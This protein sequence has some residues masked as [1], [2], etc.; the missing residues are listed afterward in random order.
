MKFI[1]SWH[2]VERYAKRIPSILVDN[3]LVSVMKCPS[4]SREMRCDS[5]VC[6]PI[7]PF[8]KTNS[9]VHSDDK[10][11][12]RTNIYFCEELKKN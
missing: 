7:D 6:C 8:S 4:S 2:D 9:V 5:H 3:V 10:S 1:R 12:I 11:K